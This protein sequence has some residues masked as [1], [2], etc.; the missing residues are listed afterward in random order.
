MLILI[1]IF[2]GQIMLMP[3]L[4]VLF[5]AILAL[6]APVAGADEG[7]DES[8]KG[9][10]RGSYSSEREW[11]SEKR[12]D[13]DR[14][15][16]YFHEHG[17]TRLSIPPGHYPPPG[18]CRIWYPD[19]PAGQQPPPGNCRSVPPGAWAIRHPHD[20]PGYVHVDVYEPRRGGA[21]LVVGEFKIASGAFVRIVVEP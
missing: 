16:S 7:K 4:Q 1:L 20:R 9:R 3:S 11:K 19:R 14:E 18:E 8:G 17:Y 13:D 6:A 21:L 15:S 10:E 12:R 5:A 2:P